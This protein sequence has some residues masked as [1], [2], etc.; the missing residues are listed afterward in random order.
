M[1]SQSGNFIPFLSVNNYEGRSLEVLLVVNVDDDAMV[2]TEM[3]IVDPVGP[4][5]LS[6]VDPILPLLHEDCKQK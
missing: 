3:A 2:T 5:R 6:A 4:G 1:H